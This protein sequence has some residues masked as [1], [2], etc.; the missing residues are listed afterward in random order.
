MVDPLQN[1]SVS[2]WTSSQA[3]HSCDLRVCAPA[4][5]R[6]G[7]CLALVG[8]IRLVLF[9]LRVCCLRAPGFLA[10]L[11][12]SQENVRGSEGRLKVQQWVESTF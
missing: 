8:I 5:E 1:G 11:R 6:L 2:G 7:Y 4:L 12:D 3:Q 10:L 9:L